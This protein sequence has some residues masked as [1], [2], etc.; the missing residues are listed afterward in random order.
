[1]RSM[2]AKV[3]WWNNQL[4]GFH[5][6]FCKHS[7]KTGMRLN[8]IKTKA[9][10]GK[11]K[12]TNSSITLQLLCLGSVFLWAIKIDRLFPVLGEIKHKRFVWKYLVCLRRRKISFDIFVKHRINHSQT[13]KKFC[14]TK[15]IYW[16]CVF[17]SITW[18]KF[19]FVS[20]TQWSDSEK[21]LFS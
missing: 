17:A 3:K 13:K 11:R 14:K 7:W 8:V 16:T 1:M 10:R 19:E 18:P 6:E 12:K 5:L 20:R 4:Y 15:E 9:N 2:I 21:S